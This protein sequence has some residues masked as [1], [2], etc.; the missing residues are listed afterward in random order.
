M[1]NFFELFVQF[2]ALFEPLYSSGGINHFSFA[3]EEWMALA[4]QLNA[5]LFLG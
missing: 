4:A 1:L 2:V 5:K 3:G